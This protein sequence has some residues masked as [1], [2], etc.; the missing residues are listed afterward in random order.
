MS[1]VVASAATLEALTAKVD[2]LRAQGFALVGG[3]AVVPGAVWA[4]ALV[5]DFT[6]PVDQGPLVDALNRRALADQEELVA[7]RTAVA[8]MSANSAPHVT[9]A[10]A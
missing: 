4:Q 5:R 2:E 9:D 3:I 10:G 8:D 6:P 7:L 1:Y